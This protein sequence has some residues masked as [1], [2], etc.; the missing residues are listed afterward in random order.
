MG[1]KSEFLCK[2]AFISNDNRTMYT[3]IDK[4]RDTFFRAFRRY[5]LSPWQVEPTGGL[6]VYG[7]YHIY[8]DKDWQPMVAEQLQRLRD[9]GLLQYSKRLY[10]SCILL[11]EEDEATLRRMLADEKVEIVAMTRDPKK[12]E[13]PALEFIREKSMEGE[14]LFYYFHTKG[15]TYQQVHTN[16]RKFNAFKRNINAWR[17]LMEYFLMDQ[18]KVAVNVLDQDYDTYGC[19]RLPPPPRDYYL[20]AG[21][22][23]WA[24]ASYLRRLPG[25]DAKRMASD[26]FFAEEWLYKARPKDFSAFDTMA[27]LYYVYLP[28]SLYAHRRLPLWE[29]VKFT[30]V[31]NF[32]K[33]RKQYF[34]HD[35]KAEYQQRYQVLR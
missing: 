15:I 31:Y 5:D 26:R 24:K 8:C 10:V 3:I 22:F 27:D 32:R 18:W 19:Y 33:M 12:F 29:A 28:E 9:S 1:Y 6:P 20:Y 7:V 25:F 11:H 14:A 34:H 23:W 13:Y 21:N 2:F 30:A 4:F 16:D 35:Y 17:H